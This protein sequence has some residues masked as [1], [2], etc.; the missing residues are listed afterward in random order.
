VGVIG[1]QRRQDDPDERA[2]GLIIDMRTKEKRRGGERITL[3]G[4][5]SSRGRHHRNPPE[6]TGQKGIVLS[7]ERHPVFRKAASWKTSGSPVT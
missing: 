6:R 7:R 3:Y 1:P 5:S 2:L 4:G